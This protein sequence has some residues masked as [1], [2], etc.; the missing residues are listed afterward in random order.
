MSRN[1]AE[2]H[3]VPSI[4]P[5]ECPKCGETLYAWFFYHLGRPFYGKVCM[6]CY[7]YLWTNREKKIGRL[8]DNVVYSVLDGTCEEDSIKSRVHLA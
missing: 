8:L 2:I 4:S 6:R 5:K 7:F 3:I 1:H